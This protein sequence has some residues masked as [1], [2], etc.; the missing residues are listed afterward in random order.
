MNFD[1]TQT[2]PTTEALGAEAKASQ[3]LLGKFKVWRGLSLVG[4]LVGD[5][6]V[7]AVCAW[8]STLFLIGSIAILFLLPSRAETRLHFAALM[9]ALGVVVGVLPVLFALNSKATV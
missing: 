1:I 6:A 7:A 4:F 3:A 5:I 9:G 2:P 8:Y